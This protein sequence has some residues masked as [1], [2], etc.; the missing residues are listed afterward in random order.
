MANLG[1]PNDAIKL[2]G[3]IYANSTTSFHGN[4]FSTTPPIHISRGTFQ[5]DTLS[6][7]L[8]IIFLKPLLRWLEVGSLGYHF[9]TSKNTCTTTTNSDDL[10][11]LTYNINYLQPQINKQIFF[12]EWA[13]MDLN[14]IKCTI[15]G[16][17]N[18]A[19]LKPTIFTTFI[20]AQRITFK[21]KRFPILTQN[22]PYTYLGI[23][24][25]PLLE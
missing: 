7:Y 1:F 3:D 22:E 16:I 5:G 25:V 15:I 19:K 2:L 23:Q 17:P 11:I 9:N 10:A 20:Q 18:Q 4:Y 6:P 14:S 24:L 8:F 13:H 21:A 12:A